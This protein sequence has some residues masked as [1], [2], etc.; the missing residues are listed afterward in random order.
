MLLRAYSD[1]H[2]FLPTVEPC[3]ALLIAGDIC[4]ID[5]EFGDHSPA[6]QARWIEQYFNPWIDAQP[7]DRVVLIG[8]NHDAILD[9]DYAEGCA[10]QLHSRVEY[11]VDGGTR[12]G[13]DGPTVWG[14]PWIPTLQNWPFYRSD[15]QLRE[16]AA[17]VPPGQDIWLLHSPP[18]SA[19]PS[20]GLDRTHRGVRAGKPIMTDRIEELAPKLII[21]GHIHEGF[22]LA[23]LAGVPVANVAY[24]DQGYAPRHRHLAVEYDC[25]AGSVAAMEMVTT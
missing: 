20:Y 7:T 18:A 6:S 4:P 22:G 8:G 24:V 16:I 17:A 21:C 19:E 2:G 9:P 25:A 5:G 11:L 3:D 1:L 15:D 12:L 13:E 14:Q 23:E 10:Y